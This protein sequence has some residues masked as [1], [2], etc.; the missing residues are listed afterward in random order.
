MSTPSIDNDIITSVTDE[1]AKYAIVD[2]IASAKSDL[3]VALDYTIKTD[4][5]FLE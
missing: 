4:P 2:L 5:R 3:H 1:V